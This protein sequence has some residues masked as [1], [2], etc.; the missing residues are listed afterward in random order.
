M[1][2]LVVFGASGD[3]AK[4]KLFPA[5]SS[6]EMS[7]TQIIGYA[8]SDLVSSFTDELQEFHSY[9]KAFLNS[10]RYIQG[11]YDDL[12]NLEFLRNEKPVFYFSVPP[13]VYPVLLA[14]VAKTFGDIPIGIEKPFG[15]DIASFNELLESKNKN[16][17]FIDHYL[18]KPSMIAL[19]LVNKEAIFRYLNGK[20]V[21]S[22]L[23]CFNEKL[24]AEGREAFDKM[25][26]IRDTMQNHLTTALCSLISEDQNGTSR[27][28]L[29]ENFNI[30]ACSAV[31]GQYEGYAAE[32]NNESSTESFAC[33][34][35]SISAE[36]WKNVD[37]ML[38]GGKG[39]NEKATEIKID[40]REERIKEILR[41]I[42]IECENTTSLSLVFNIAPKGELSLL[43]NNAEKHVLLSQADISN[44]VLKKYNGLAEY[45]I[46]FK[47]LV[48]GKD[49]G[50]S[51]VKEVAEMWRIL[52]EV[53][54][55]E[56]KLHYYKKGDSLDEIL[57]RTKDT[58]K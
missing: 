56:K 54:S 32:F 51:D 35:C 5:L 46:I 27:L 8:R 26:M 36:N 37:F 58:K 57:E 9:E 16:L 49:F 44:Y 22:I 11:E 31:Y 39:M 7:D 34:N 14:A 13:K 12:Q 3:L 42:S 10:L 55:Q 50:H 38:A 40:F 45:E 30:D 2:T 33:M 24:G 29:L 48:E 15:E 41:G 47:S 6:L 28:K 25:G 52:A 17:F 1:P 43:M 4:R 23:A 19:P 20:N 53:M 18:L 21:A